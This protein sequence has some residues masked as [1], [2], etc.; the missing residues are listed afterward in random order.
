MISNNQCL[1][2][3]YLCTNLFLVLVL[4]LLLVLGSW[5]LFLVHGAVYIHGPV[6]V[7][8]LG[9]GP[10]LV[11]GTFLALSPV[12]SPFLVLGPVLVPGPGPVQWP[13]LCIQCHSSWSGLTP[14]HRHRD[15]LA[16]KVEHP[17]AK[18]PGI[19]SLR[20]WWRPNQR[21]K[22]IDYWTYSRFTRWTQ[23]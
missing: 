6:L 21:L 9:L 22:E 19:L 4:V 14:N 7:L 15:Q 2:A 8:V 23:T 20:N 17:A 1:P 5:F 12:P 10:V 13:A 11:L 3:V 18:G 16:E